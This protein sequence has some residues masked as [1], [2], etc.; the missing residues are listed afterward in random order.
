MYW[1]S[2][3]TKIKKICKVTEMN[4]VCNDMFDLGN[5]VFYMSTIQTRQS[6][7]YC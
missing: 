4:T 5:R 1:S 6:R 7:E 3:D 2:I